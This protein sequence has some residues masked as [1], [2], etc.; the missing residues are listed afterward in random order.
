MTVCAR[1]VVALVA[2]KTSVPEGKRVPF[3]WQ[4]A[5]ITSAPVVL[6]WPD[7]DATVQPTRLRVTVAI[8]LKG[9][10]YV[11]A[12]LD[13]RDI[14]EVARRCLE[15]TDLGYDVFTVMSTQESL[16]KVAVSYTCQRLGWKPRYDFS[17]LREP[18]KQSVG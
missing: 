15:K 18:A 14:G 17:W 7:M 10:R 13:R 5:A 11:E 9:E 2:G 3:G 6:T 4:A 1:H 12:S 8:D 16:H